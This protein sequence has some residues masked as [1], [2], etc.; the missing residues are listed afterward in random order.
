MWDI[1]VQKSGAKGI[2]VNDLNRL[3]GRAA[4]D[5]PSTNHAKPKILKIVIYIVFQIVKY[6]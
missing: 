6:F 3:K 1:Q 2:Q 5:L 4:R